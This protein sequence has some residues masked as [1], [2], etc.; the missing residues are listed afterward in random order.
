MFR[1]RG[2]FAPKGLIPVAAVAV[3]AVGGVAVLQLLARSGE[4]AVRMIPADA[5]VAVTF[6]TAPSPAQV[7][8]FN[9][10]KSAFEDSGL[11]DLVDGGLF[12]MDES[13][14]LSEIRSHIKGSFAAGLWGDLKGGQPDVIIALALNDPSGAERL[15]ARYAKPRNADGMR[16]YTVPDEKMLITFHRGYALLSNRVEAAQK[17]LR[18]AEGV[19]PNLYDQPAFQAARASLPAD[20]NLMVFVNGAAIA[21]SDPEARDGFKALGID[22]NGWLALGVTLREEGIQVDATLPAAGQGLTAAMGRTQP[23]T[24]ASLERFPEGAVGAAGLSGPAR[25]IEVILDIVRASEGTEEMDSGIA[26]LEAKTGLSFEKDFLPALRGEIVGALYPPITPGGD[27][28]VILALDNS[29]GGRATEVALDLFEKLNAGLFDSPEEQPRLIETRMGD[30]RVFRPTHQDDGQQI[31]LAVSAEQVM[32]I[33]DP[34]LLMRIAEGPSG[35][36]LLETEGFADLGYNSEAR[37]QLQIDME[38]FIGALEEAGEA[39]E[40][41][42]LRQILAGRELTATWT[43]DGAAARFRLLIPIDIPELI[44]VAGAKIVSEHGR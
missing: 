8:L 30:L 37:L 44:M 35:T 43:Y 23:L 26:E 34:G 25:F 13:G 3:A 14:V 10:I 22:E 24:F 40:D 19:E 42:D 5:V 15:V 9:R 18:T 7:P 6:D 33:S 27:P 17:A 21:E 39:P 31:A 1:T 28:T 11:E 12:G 20:A 36:N 29:S 32:L 41:F 4:A 16:Y 38:R 2:V